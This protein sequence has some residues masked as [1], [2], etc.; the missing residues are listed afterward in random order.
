M[1][2]I[3]DAGIE[4]AL[5]DR[6]GCDLPEFAAFALL[7]TNEGREALTEY[8]RPFAQ[9]AVNHSLP[10]VL[11][12]PTWRA[13]PDWGQVLGYDGE[14]L[15]RINA[16]AV[17][18]TRDV[19]EQCA[20]GHEVTV[21]GVVGPRYDDDGATTM[22]AQEA[23]DYHLPQVRALAAADADRVTAVTMTDAGEAEG[24]TRAAQAVGV[25][26]VVSFSVGPD[27]RLASGASLAE[28]IVTVDEATGGYPVGYMINCAH[29]SEAVLALREARDHGGS[30]IPRITGF[31]LNA[32]QHGDDGPG[33]TPEAFADA[34]LGLRVYAPEARTMGGCCGTDAPH[35]AAIAE[36]AAV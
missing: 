11:D 33:D 24:V 18:F 4:T 26:V 23:Y 6:L 9:L 15:D 5:T 27:G 17:R 30:A 29:P 3:A 14:A 21:A 2:T 36:R 16:D 25:P 10:L 1:F 8:F 20:P 12:T 28:A 35:I 19:A 7:D 13:N 32:A 22:T 31:K 34:V